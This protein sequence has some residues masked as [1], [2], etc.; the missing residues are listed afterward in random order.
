MFGKQ[1]TAWELGSMSY[2]CVLCKNTT[3]WSLRE[4]GILALARR[5]VIRTAIIP[6]WADISWLYQ[7]LFQPGT[8]SGGSPGK[9]S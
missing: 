4:D 2:F 5:G 3:L 7:A 6:G 8:G 9:A 1:A